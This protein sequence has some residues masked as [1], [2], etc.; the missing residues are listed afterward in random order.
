MTKKAKRLSFNFSSFI[1]LATVGW[2]GQ[3]LDAVASTLAMPFLSGKKFYAAVPHGA[4]VRHRP[5][6][7]RVSATAIDAARP[8]EPQPQT[9]QTSRQSWWLS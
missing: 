5:K 6:T 7:R 9:T 8:G 1:L 4:S 3:T 2:K